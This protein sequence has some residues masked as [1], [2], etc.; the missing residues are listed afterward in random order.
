MT[1][2]RKNKRR[3]AASLIGMCLLTGSLYIPVY[4]NAED[5]PFQEKTV[6]DTENDNTDNADTAGTDNGQTGSQETADGNTD[7]G[8]ADGG[9]ASD[10][11]S[12]QPD[13]SDTGNGA[14]G[15]GQPAGTEESGEDLND[16]QTED[17]IQTE[18]G[19]EKV[20]TEDVVRDQQGQR[21]N[22]WR[23]RNGKLLEPPQYRSRTAPYPHAWEKV[24]G[25]YMNSAGQPIEGAVK[26]G[27]DVS[28][29][30]KKIDWEKVKADGI[31]FAIIQCGYGND[32]SYQD[33]E[34]WAYNVSECERLGIPYGVYLYS[35]AINVKEAKSE[36]EH[37]LRL[38]SGH[39]PS[40]P[41]YLDMEDDSTKDLKAELKGQIAQTFCDT[42]SAQGYQVGIYANLNWWST[43]LTSPVFENDTW[44]R[45][46]AQYNTTCDY[47]DPYDMWQATSKGEVDGIEGSVDVNFWMNANKDY[48]SATVYGTSLAVKR[49]NEY[50][51]K[52]VLDDGEADLVINYGNA[53]DIVLVGDWNGDGID[54]LCIRRGN[55]YYFK[56]SL[57]NG[58][59]DQV[60]NYGRSSDEVLVGDWNG[61][62][63]DTLCVRRGNTY[64]LKNSLGNGEADKVV[65]YGKSADTVLV[66]DWNGDGVDTLCVRRGNNYHVKNTL[67]D[68]PADSVVPYGKASDV[69][70][71][72]DWDADQVDTL[73]VR[74][75]SEYHIKNSIQ[76]GAADQIIYYGRKGDTIY[77]GKWK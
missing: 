66:G 57:S 18:D 39:S 33:D 55:T 35:Y 45:W 4:V 51:F 65:A 6:Q 29:A 52:Y 74:R 16:S 76:S 59:A 8:Q 56:N 11:G 77:T 1:N 28:Y 38:L 36:A 34:Y 30:Q 47:A 53:D 13:I 62:G 64:Y 63:T 72:G 10:T 69:I 73:C 41:V 12:G 23:Y 7:P 20:Q 48:G 54:T 17:R 27:I 26:K 44:S 14:E 60:V 42:V 9:G 58:E 24:N 43:Q 50:H 70:L 71:V 25:V 40:Y 31:D 75:G 49:G 32:L 61:D 3:V 19:Q 67:A 37:V 2:L 68:G 22:S 15:T 5:V 21:P 46:V